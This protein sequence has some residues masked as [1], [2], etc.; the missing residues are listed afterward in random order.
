[1]QKSVVVHNPFIYMSWIP[2]N[3]QAPRRRII[4]TT[5]N[6]SFKIYMIIRNLLVD[7]RTDGWMDECG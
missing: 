2:D 1:M 7:G 4:K 3:M 6:K 5:R